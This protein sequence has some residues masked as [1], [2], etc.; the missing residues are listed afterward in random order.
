MRGRDFRV[1]SRI[2][3]RWD[4]RCDIGLEGRVGEEEPEQCEAKGNSGEG[5]G[6]T[7][8]VQRRILEE[9]AKRSTRNQFCK[10]ITRQCEPEA[11]LLHQ[12]QLP[13]WLPSPL[14]LSDDQAQQQGASSAGRGCVG[15]GD[16]E[17]WV[18]V[19]E[20]PMRCGSRSA[21]KGGLFGMHP[22]RPTGDWLFVLSEIVCKDRATWEHVT[23][24]AGRPASVLTEDEIRKECKEVCAN[25]A[26]KPDI[27]DLGAVLSNSISYRKK[28]AEFTYLKG[29]GWREKS[30]ETGN[31]EEMLDA[32]F[33]LGCTAD[34]FNTEPTENDLMAMV[35]D[36]SPTGV[37]PEVLSEWRR[38]TFEDARSKKRFPDSV[39]TS[40]QKG[41]DTKFGVDIL[42]NNTP[43]R[44]CYRS[45]A[46]LDKICP[47]GS[48]ACGEV[49]I[50]TLARLDAWICT[51][52]I[53]ALRDKKTEPDQATP[54]ESGDGSAENEDA[55]KGANL[56]GS[57]KNS[58]HNTMFT[59]LL[60]R[61]IEGVLSQFREGVQKVRPQELFMPF[62]YDEAAKM[63]GKDDKVD[64]EALDALA[65]SKTTSQG[66][67]GHGGNLH[68]QAW[69]HITSSH[70]S[71]F[72][73]LNYV[74][75]LPSF[76]R[77]HVCGWIGDV[78]DAFVGVCD[79]GNEY[80]PITASARGGVAKSPEVG[81]PRK[82]KRSSEDE[83][84]E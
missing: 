77:S 72:D 63:V 35:Q 29:L 64:D 25:N 52:M 23:D 48:E 41:M 30:N 74:V 71:P 42:F 67:E 83:S 32:V 40:E 49:S 58:I 2:G 18:L 68:A 51:S 46:K 5:K 11:L 78:R 66:P 60:P 55:K 54:V 3:F 39:L 7:V 9:C 73:E 15:P 65:S 61:A 4:D 14:R 59:V 33:G 47:P 13:K 62:D 17:S 81:S 6:T 70:L 56:A 24:G 36:T 38:R 37:T 69:R 26:A 22:G 82:G 34:D 19:A 80:V 16:P 50:L 28:Q 10:A 75:V 84:E 1:A 21:M 76:V 53:M 31:E 44:N 43:A 27:K 45:W 79:T 12:L 20:P 8:S 57:T